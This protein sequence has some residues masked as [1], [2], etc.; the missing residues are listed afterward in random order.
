MHHDAKLHKMQWFEE[1]PDCGELY[2][3]ISLIKSFETF[4]FK[5][6]L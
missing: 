6:D 3:L 2:I 5:Q 1:I 4:L